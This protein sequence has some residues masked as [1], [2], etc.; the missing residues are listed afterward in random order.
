MLLILQKMIVNSIHKFY[1]F[2]RTEGSRVCWIK[3]DS[4]IVQSSLIKFN[5]VH[6]SA[7]K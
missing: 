4:M 5:Q 3:C 2:V 1:V 7:C 6:T